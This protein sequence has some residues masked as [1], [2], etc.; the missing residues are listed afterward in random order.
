MRINYTNYNSIP[1]RNRSGH[2][3]VA[4][5]RSLDRRSRLGKCSQFL[6]YQPTSA[7]CLIISSAPFNPP[8]RR[9]P[10]ASR[11]HDT[12]PSCL[13]VCLLHDPFHCHCHIPSHPFTTPTSTPPFA[14]ILPSDTGVAM[15]GEPLTTLAQTQTARVKLVWTHE[16]VAEKHADELSREG[17]GDGDGDEDGE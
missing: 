5:E 8:L 10:H 7:P 3:S 17:D 9:P 1:C 12:P 11:I 4:I 2:H 16:S 6:F 15:T 13:F 14:V